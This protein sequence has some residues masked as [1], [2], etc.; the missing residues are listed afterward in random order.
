MTEG[1]KQPTPETTLE[2]KITRREFLRGMGRLGALLLVGSVTGVKIEG[3]EER[4]HRER[5][6][7]YNEI[8]PPELVKRIVALEDGY[9]IQLPLPGE[10]WFCGP[11][12]REK[13]STE[14]CPSC[15]NR[16]WFKTEIDQSEA[17]FS[18]LPTAIK[19][20]VR[21]INP[22][23]IIS[24]SVIAVLGG[25]GCFTPP[26]IIYINGEETKENLEKKIASYS[27]NNE[28][29]IF[30]NWGQKFRY[31]VG[32]ELAH[33]IQHARPETVE[34]WTL[35]T[36]WSQDEKGLWR[37]LPLE[38]KTVWFLIQSDPRYGRLIKE[39]IKQDKLPADFLDIKE[40]GKSLKEN[41]LAGR[42]AI[43]MKHR[44]FGLLYGGWSIRGSFAETSGELNAFNPVEDMAASMALTFVF[45]S[46]ESGLDE[47]R[48]K[49]LSEFYG[50]L[51]RS[52]DQ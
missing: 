32:E 19:N 2:K 15:W 41:K 5:I 37:N 43:A 46:S 50:P 39:L 3:E 45:P 49:V 9:N 47:T 7:K 28:D 10:I 20:L 22:H 8:Y 24:N 33:A 31:V 14:H 16:H 40:G 26:N 1:E 36:G 51:A 18:S 17:L 25:Q 38:R 6:K 13:Y 29:I 4:N 34:D 23:L 12:D 52:K 30:K 48:K 42:M 35:K 21:E 11:A 44:V 27:P